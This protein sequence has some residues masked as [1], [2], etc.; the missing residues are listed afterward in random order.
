MITAIIQARVSSTRFPNKVFADICGKPLIWHVVNRLKW[1]KEIEKI[2]LATS[3]N[4]ADNILEAW[5][6]ENGV[7]VYRG[8]ENDVLDRY[9]KA[10]LLSGASTIVRVT[11]DDPFKDPQVIDDVINVLKGG[12][13]D[14]AY[15]NNPPSFPEGLDTE[16]FTF[17]ALKK[18]AAESTDLF[19]REHVTQ[20][21]YRNPLLFSQTNFSYIEN[22]SH[23][24]WTID[25]VN[26]YE[27]TKKVYLDLYK[28][29]SI[30]LF[31]DILNY[32]EKHP[33]VQKMNIY[34]NRSAMYCKH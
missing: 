7:T 33:E 21:F 23:L 20:Y 25:T 16:V 14:F 27:M 24:R 29:G 1:S 3:E 28:E 22:V 13:Y 4:T 8:S 19:E 31:R 5:G 30:F 11:A 12:C 18:A 26:D 6:V 9:Y 2:V 15:N 32:L 34:E 17:E 10:A